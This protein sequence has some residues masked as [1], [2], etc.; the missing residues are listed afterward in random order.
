[1]LSPDTAGHQVRLTE[2]HKPERPSERERIEAAGGHVLRAGPVW[3]VSRLSAQVRGPVH[4]D[5]RHRAKGGVKARDGGRGAKA[6]NG[7]GEGLQKESTN[8]L[9]RVKGGAVD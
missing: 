5:G 3:R 7:N 2:D 6:R 8:G 1:M 9:A 4:S